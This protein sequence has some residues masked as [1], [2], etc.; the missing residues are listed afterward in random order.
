MFPRDLLTATNSGNKWGSWCTLPGPT[1]PSRGIL[2]GLD[3]LKVQLLAGLANTV[4]EQTQMNL[5]LEKPIP[6]AT[7]IWKREG[8]RFSSVLAPG[9]GGRLKP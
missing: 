6:Q 2:R 9:R 1:V 5:L 8:G 4:A 7:S 3:K